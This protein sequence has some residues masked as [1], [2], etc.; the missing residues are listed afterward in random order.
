M[1]LGT[2]IFL[3]SIFLGLIFLFHS[4]KDRWNWRKIIKRGGVTILVLI[5]LGGGGFTALIYQHQISEYFSTG[6]IINLDASP[7]KYEEVWDIKLGASQEDLLFLKG[8]PS[9]KT[10]NK[11]PN[12]KVWFYKQE[13]GDNWIV[14]FD[15]NDKV[16]Q[17]LLYKIYMTSDIKINGISYGSTLKTLVNKLGKPSRIIVSKDKLRKFYLY[18]QL[19][20][21]FVLEKA[22]VVA[23]GI[24]KPL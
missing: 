12:E 6:S 9:S 16:S 2:G 21:K 1:T 23:M 14:D 22:K 13:Y 19:N 10:S 20:N 7:K 18:D 15:K 4:T 3:S 11:D 17:V 5:I 24:N 8:I